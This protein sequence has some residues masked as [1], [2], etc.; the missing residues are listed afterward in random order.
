MISVPVLPS[1]AS[2]CSAAHVS[3]GW[4]DAGQAGWGLSAPCGAPAERA[5]CL[6]FSCFI[7]PARVYP[8]RARNTLGSSRASQPPALA[9][10][11]AGAGV[12]EASGA[13]RSPREPGPP[14][15]GRVRE[16]QCRTNQVVYI[17][18][19][20][21]AERTE[22]RDLNR[23]LYSHVPNSI[24]HRVIMFP[25]KS[26]SNPSARKIRPMHT[27]KSYSALERNSDPCYLEDMM[28]NKPVIV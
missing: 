19:G 17:P 27:M 9:Q 16:T 22:S 3:P 5:A 24:I 26:G 12:R 21:T 4:E 8:A 25:L 10:H 20:Y 13:Q 28:L 18:S 6:P 1:V 14:I 7:N 23:Y 11:R 15:A 2:K